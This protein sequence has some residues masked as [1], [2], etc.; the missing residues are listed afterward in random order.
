MVLRFQHHDWV[1][2]TL[3]RICGSR[4]TGELCGG[5]EVG[6]RSF[7]RKMAILGRGNK[8]KSK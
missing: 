6:D 3:G 4:K 5:K 2:S 1:R 8:A 7:S